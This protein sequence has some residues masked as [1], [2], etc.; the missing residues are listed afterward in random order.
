MEK[1]ENEFDTSRQMLLDG[2]TLSLEIYGND[3]VANS[4]IYQRVAR[5][6]IKMLLEHSEFLPDVA[7]YEMVNLHALVDE[8]VITRITNFSKQSKQPILEANFCYM[9][10]LE[11]CLDRATLS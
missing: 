10:L 4:R 7:H 9:L 6:I 2:I 11:T 5:L 8:V 3:K 1:P